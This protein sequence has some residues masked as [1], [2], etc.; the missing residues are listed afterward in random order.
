[1]HECSKTWGDAN[2]FYLKA[3][4]KMAE[5]FDGWGGF[6]PRDHEQEEVEVRGSSRSSQSLRRLQGHGDDVLEYRA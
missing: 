5:D 2:Q 6:G 4:V 1:M 3:A